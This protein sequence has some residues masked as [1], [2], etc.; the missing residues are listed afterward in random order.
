[1][2]THFRTLFHVAVNQKI[3]FQRR[4]ISFPST[5]CTHLSTERSRLTVVHGSPPRAL[6]GGV[7]LDEGEVE[8]VGQRELGDVAGR[9]FLLL[10][11]LEAG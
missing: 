7:T 4:K 9:V 3:T 2:Q 1:V 8:S 5:Y 10:I 11:S 6:L